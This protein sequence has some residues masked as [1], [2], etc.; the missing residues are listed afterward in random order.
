MKERKGN[1]W[2][3]AEVKRWKDVDVDALGRGA[4]SG[5]LAPRVCPL[6]CAIQGYLT[7]ASE[8][9]STKNNNL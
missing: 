7:Y 2:W 5:D 8:P 6:A 3:T 1:W 4:C 9:L